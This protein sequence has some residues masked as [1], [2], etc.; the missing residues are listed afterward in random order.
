[1]YMIFLLLIYCWNYHCYYYLWHFVHS[2][3]EGD[4]PPSNSDHH[5]FIYLYGMFCR[6]WSLYGTFTNT[7]SGIL[8]LSGANVLLRYGHQRR[9]FKVLYVTTKNLQTCQHFHKYLGNIFFGGVHLHKSEACPKISQTF[10]L[11]SFSTSILGKLASV[12][13][14]WEKLNNQWIIHVGFSSCHHVCFT[15]VGQPSQ[16]ELL[17]EDEI[18]WFKRR[19]R[20]L[21]CVV[22]LCHCPGEW[23]KRCFFAVILLDNPWNW[24]HGVPLPSITNKRWLGRMDIGFIFLKHP[25]ENGIPTSSTSH[26][27]QFPEIWDSIQQK[28]RRNSLCV[29]YGR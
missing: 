26:I 15:I 27:L 4:A 18:R 22:N 10:L 5:M 3:C 21:M 12:L 28:K 6:W 16:A 23:L 25:N 9:Y 14:G 24:K 19:I 17:P 2:M 1:M 8:G 29:F 20:W 11:T 13:A 7:F